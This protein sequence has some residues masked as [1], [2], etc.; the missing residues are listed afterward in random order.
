MSQHATPWLLLG[1]PDEVHAPLDQRLVRRLEIGD[2]ERDA[3][4]AA[5]QVASLLVIPGSFRSR[6]SC[7]SPVASWAQPVSSL[8]KVAGMPSVSV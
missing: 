4:E 2:L 7:A 8:R 1:R 5:D 3:D 6:A